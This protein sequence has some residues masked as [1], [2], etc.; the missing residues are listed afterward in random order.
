ML[1]PQCTLI[2]DGAGLDTAA[3]SHMDGGHRKVHAGVHSTTGVYHVKLGAAPDNST[4][5]ARRLD[6]AAAEPLVGVHSAPPKTAVSA[7]GA[8]KCTLTLSGPAAPLLPQCTLTMFSQVEKLALRAA[9]LYRD[10]CCVGTTRT[11]HISSMLCIST[12]HKRLARA[13]HLCKRFC[14]NSSTAL[15][16]RGFR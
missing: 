2:L 4:R 6:A 15:A 11:T 5:L 12:V 7:D 16:K 1:L 9:L 14:V 13:G 8:G 10:F 3:Q